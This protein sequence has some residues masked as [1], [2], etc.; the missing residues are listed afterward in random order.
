MSA[1]VSFCPPLLLPKNFLFLSQSTKLQTFSANHCGIYLANPATKIRQKRDNEATNGKKRQM[2]KDKQHK[3]EALRLHKLGVEPSRIAAKLGISVRTIQRW[4][5]D[6]KPVSV[7]IVSTKADKRSPPSI[8]KNG[9]VCRDKFDLTFSRKTAI[10]LMNLAA[11]ALNTLEEVLANPDA[12]PADKLRAAKIL[13]DWLDVGA[14]A[15]YVAQVSTNSPSFSAQ[16]P[17]KALQAVDEDEED[18][19]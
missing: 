6:E 5:K 4:L 19:E 17:P 18:E 13:G 10:R 2:A 14:P 3:N 16:P 9:A 1:I 15:R 8:V 11:L 12:R 7:S